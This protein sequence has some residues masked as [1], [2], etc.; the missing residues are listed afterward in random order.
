MGEQHT[1]CAD[2]FSQVALFMM[3]K[4]IYFG[5]N[6]VLEFCL[7]FI[8]SAKQRLS[9][10]FFNSINMISTSIMDMT[11]CLYVA[12]C[13]LI[14]IIMIK[15]AEE[16]FVRFPKKKVH[17]NGFN[18]WDSSICLT[19]N[20]EQYFSLR[21]HS[22]GEFFGHGLRRTTQQDSFSQLSSPVRVTACEIAEGLCCVN[23]SPIQALTAWSCDSRIDVTSTLNDHFKTYRLV[24]S[25]V[26]VRS[27]SV[28][29][30]KQLIYWL[31]D[32]GDAR[33]PAGQIRPRH[34]FMHR[35][36]RV[37]TQVAV[38]M[39]TSAALPNG[40]VFLGFFLFHYRVAFC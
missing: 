13:V 35:S 7:S 3:L 26:A 19:L 20:S 31:S 17:R 8:V 1:G 14:L 28:R 18:L 29:H 23:S 40:S 15:D 5:N 11:Y 2:N 10:F 30:C 37:E 34:E 12:G 39:C 22:F 6:I 24:T 16:I 4:Q 25:L 32:Y 9:S 27:G 33:D 38:C 21:N 36:L